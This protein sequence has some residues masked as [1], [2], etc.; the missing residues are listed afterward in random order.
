MI[1]KEIGNSVGLVPSPGVFF[2]RLLMRP[3][4]GDHIH[5]RAQHAAEK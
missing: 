1:I 5:D 2:N 3:G 4:A